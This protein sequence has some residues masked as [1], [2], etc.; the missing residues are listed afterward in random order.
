MTKKYCTEC[1]R[2]WS[3][4]NF[5]SV[6]T[7]VARLWPRKLT[8][9]YAQDRAFFP[10]LARVK[11]SHLF[12]FFIVYFFFPYGYVYTRKLCSRARK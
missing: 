7:F 4:S 10:K 9:S 1:S 2:N 5:Y 8:S 12:D 6:I 11:K 3:S